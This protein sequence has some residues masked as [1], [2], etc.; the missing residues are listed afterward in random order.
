MQS[1]L[2]DDKRKPRVFL[3]YAAFKFSVPVY[4]PVE[5]YSFP[6]RLI[7]FLTQFTQWIEQII[8]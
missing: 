1:R 6:F 2:A 8:I 4:K 3:N 5:K 7:L